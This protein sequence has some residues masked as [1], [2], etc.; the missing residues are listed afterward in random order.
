MVKVGGGLI[1]LEQFLSYLI[2]CVSECVCNMCD[3]GVHVWSMYMS[4]CMVC[5]C[6]CICMSVSVCTCVC[7]SMYV[8]MCLCV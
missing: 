5:V 4:V 3:C 7:T 8:S 6:V 1:L 2:L